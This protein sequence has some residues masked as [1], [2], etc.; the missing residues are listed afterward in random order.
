[1]NIFTQTESANF[2][3]LNIKKYKSFIYKMYLVYC[4]LFKSGQTFLYETRPWV[5][6]FLKNQSLVY[7]T[8]PLKIVKIS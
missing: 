4:Y 5:K 6:E 7:F 8:S 1:M 3:N 2:H